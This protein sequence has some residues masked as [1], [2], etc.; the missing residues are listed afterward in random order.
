MTEQT[1]Q[2]D[3]IRAELAGWVAQHWNPDLP[4]REWRELL[5]DAGWAAPSWPRRWYGRGWPA[6]TD[7]LAA[8]QLL[9]LGAVGTT[10]P[11]VTSI[12]RAHSIP[13]W[14]QKRG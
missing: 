14:R 4:L 5:A 6:W 9:A 12:Y 2:P 3:Q 1:P 10:T 8:A 13:S 11:F 7:D